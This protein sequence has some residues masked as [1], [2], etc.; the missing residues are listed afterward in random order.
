MAKKRAG[1]KK[2]Y[3]FNN[4][5]ISINLETSE[6]KKFVIETCK[7]IYA[8]IGITNENIPFS[9]LLRAVLIEGLKQLKNNFTELKEEKC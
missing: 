5:T 4:P 8:K 3:N 7:E 9:I 2:Q 1:G 6:Q